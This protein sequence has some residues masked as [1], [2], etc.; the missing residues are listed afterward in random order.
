MRNDSETVAETLYSV[1]TMLKRHKVALTVPSLETLEQLPLARFD[2]IARWI[3][4][5]DR[6]TQPKELEPPVAKVAEL[7]RR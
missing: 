7:V 6:C 5:P 1:L 3:Q 2:A 4:R